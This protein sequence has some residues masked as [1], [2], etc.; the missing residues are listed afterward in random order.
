MGEPDSEDEFSIDV[1]VSFTLGGDPV[2][3]TIS[4]YDSISDGWLISGGLGAVSLYR[5]GGL[6]LT[7]NG[8]P[9][10]AEHEVSVFPGAY[11]LGVSEPNFELKGDTVVFALE[12]Y[13][14]A[15]D[16]AIEAGLTEDALAEFRTLVRAAVDECI[17]STTLAAGCGLELPGTLSDGTVLTEG[18]IVRTLSSDTIL[19]LESLEPRLSYENPTLAQGDYIGGV[20][21]TAT[22]TKD[23]STGSCTVLFGPTLGSPS[24]DMAAE[25]P[26]VL[27]D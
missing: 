4:L 20:T 8:I 17:A 12:P 10:D 14:P 15:D 16:S 27:W 23:G 6:G 24:V 1:P 7:L 25:N 19:T 21:T 2:E 5:F 22:C 18:T 3:T 13:S 26:K 11:E 9:V